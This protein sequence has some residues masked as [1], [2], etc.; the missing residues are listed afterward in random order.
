MAEKIKFGIV[1]FGRGCSFLLAAEF[2]QDIL[3]ITSFCELPDTKAYVEEHFCKEGSKIPLAAKCKWYDDYDE[4]LKTADIDAVILCDAFY[5]HSQLAIKAMEA[6][7]PVFS[8]TTAAPTLGDCVKLVEAYERT[9]TTYALAANCTYYR[10]V[11]AMRNCVQSGKY[12]EVVFGDAEYIHPPLT[13]DYKPVDYDNIHWRQTLPSCYYNM[14]DLGPMMFITNSVPVRAVGKAVVSNY[15]PLM[16]SNKNF[17]LIEMDN[18]SVINYSG[19]TGVGSMSK[20]FRVACK[21]GTVESIRYKEFSP[22]IIESGPNHGEDYGKES[23]M[24]ER[25]Y[26]WSE[27]GVV[28]PEE[29]EKY[30]IPG[31]QSKKQGLHHGVDIAMLID[32]CKIVRGESKPFFDVYKSVALSAAGI[33]SWYSM[34]SDSKPMDI[35]D[36]T[37]KEDRDKVRDDFRTPFG[38]TLDEITL[39]FKVGE[40]FER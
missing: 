12:G 15:K 38:K 1:G 17:A 13:F 20:W 4:F 26:S 27:C 30:M 28:T 40:K 19:C 34:L 37:K 29:E 39:P 24:F 16:N 14:H 21:E 8:E 33:L 2:L 23:D 31:T 25:T 5:T 22:T 11:R 3:D 6:G 36:F 9:K 7:I 32:F 35:P 10:S 18:G